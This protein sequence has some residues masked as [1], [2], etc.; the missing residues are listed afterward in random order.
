[1]ARRVLFLRIVGVFLLCVSTLHVSSLF[2]VR[3]RL[4]WY[5]S[6]FIAI[7]C[8]FNGSMCVFV[9]PRIIKRVMER[10]EVSPKANRRE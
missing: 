2:L 3:N 5:L 7:L 4:D 8:V 6:L 10:N 9:L 1:M